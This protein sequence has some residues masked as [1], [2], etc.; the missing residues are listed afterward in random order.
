MKAQ[1]T[2]VVE[3]VKNVLGSRYGDTVACLSSL[4]SVELEGVKSEVA[5]AIIA[6][7]V[8]YGKDKT[9]TS[10]VVAY[11]RSMVMNHLKKAKELNGG[12]TAPKQ[13]SIKGI[14]ADGSASGRRSTKEL[15][16]V[17]PEETHKGVNLSPLPD[18]LRAFVQSL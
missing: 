15:S 6:G 16:P 12:L 17:V 1:K 5:R 3:T 7:E 9:N 10:E 11:A 4:T 2:Y 13:G 8:E 14:S 18:S